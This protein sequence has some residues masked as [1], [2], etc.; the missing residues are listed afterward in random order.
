[1]K[2][3]LLVSLFVFVLF[4]C[5]II[6]ISP[7]AYA[8]ENFKYCDPSKPISI[9]KGKTFVILLESNPTTGYMW[10]IANISN[11]KILKLEKNEYQAQNNDS[12]MVG[13]GGHEVWT[14]KTIGKGKSTVT[15]E[16]SR[17]WE[18]GVKP[19]KTAVFQVNVK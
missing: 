17:P 3:N 16:Y 7:R 12:N 4:I 13:A 19:V 1:M 2:N 9:S 8:E 14:F 15:F 18:K 10:K 5:Y 6:S 11:K